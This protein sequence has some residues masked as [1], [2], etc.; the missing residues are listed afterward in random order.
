MTS[1]VKGVTAI[2]AFW[3][4][5]GVVLTGAAAAQSIP[6]LGSLVIARIYVPAEFG[7]FSV[8]LG[9][10]SLLAVVVTGRYEAALAV[11]LDGEPRR[12]GVQA[13]LWCITVATGG[14]LVLVAVLAALEPAWLRTTPLALLWAFAPTAGLIAVSQV[15]QSWA[16]ADGR[17]PHLV[18][19]RISQA[20]GITGLQVGA[21]MLD[22]S[23]VSLGL[24]NC[25]G[26]LLGAVVAATLMPPGRLAESGARRDFLRRHRR[27]P[28]LSLPADSVN[29]AAGQLPL[30]LV[31]SRF[32]SDVAG[33]L[34]LALRTLGAPIGLLGAAVL[35]VFRRQAAV[36]FRE[37]GE[38]RHE[39]MQTLKVLGL[40][41]VAGAIVIG[42]FSEDLF[43]V[44]FG[45]QW[46]SAG[47]IA[48][49]LLPMFAMRFVASPLS[50]M[51]YVAHKQHVDLFWQ[52]GLMMMTATTLWLPSHYAAALQWYSAGYS[53][54][55]VVYLALSYR[56]SLGSHS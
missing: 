18:R 6:L 11:E 24:A 13:V 25:A 20:V 53:A 28:L 22:P 47:T 27:F 23:A 12:V 31:A 45:N 8:W 37:R 2:S 56:F 19:M 16:A 4:N 51:M 36:A 35:D 46:R 52:I 29:T 34:A 17:Y 48:L 44:A 15:L 39:Y 3:R 5:V 1:H 41:S 49:W 42:L 32:G 10:V 21:G 50:Y 43:A 55:Y 38:C 14:I 26:V 30:L 9:I 7:L 54:M 40:G 33:L